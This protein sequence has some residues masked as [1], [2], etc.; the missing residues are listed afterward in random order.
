MQVRQGRNMLLEHPPL[1]AQALHHQTRFLLWWCA[2]HQHSQSH[3]RQALVWSC[4]W[5]T[6]QLVCPWLPPLSPCLVL[7]PS[8]WLCSQPTLA[9]AFRA[10]ATCLWLRWPLPLK[11]LCLP[12]WAP[13]PP[14]P[15]WASPD[16]SPLPCTPNHLPGLVLVWALLARLWT[17]GSRVLALVT[18][19]WPRCLLA[20]QLVGVLIF[21]ALLPLILW[22]RLAGV[23][24]PVWT[25]F[26]PP[27]SG[28]FLTVPRLTQSMQ[29][30]TMLM[31][32]YTGKIGTPTSSSRHMLLSTM[33]FQEKSSYWAN[34]LWTY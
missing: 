32:I 16:L 2:H 10:A 20:W 11:L 27:G 14:H 9:L 23:T 28:S 22:T 34:P 19:S 8:H 29:L 13:W 15:C 4:Q 7:E 31:V 30:S 6:T 3:R 21:A 1:S 12:Q 24:I 25:T 26:I 33:W 5:A 18:C 17:W